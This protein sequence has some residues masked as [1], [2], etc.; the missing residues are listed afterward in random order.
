MALVG[1]DW[2]T[3]VTFFKAEGKSH[4]VDREKQEKSCVNVVQEPTL[5]VQACW[6]Q[7]DSLCLPEMHV[8]HGSEVSYKCRTLVQSI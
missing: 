7:E 2:A 3:F 8:A 4:T 5:S 6:L 1:E